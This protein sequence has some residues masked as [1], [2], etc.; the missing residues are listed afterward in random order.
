M[1]GLMSISVM[2]AATRDAP[3]MIDW[4]WPGTT[5]PFLRL[6]FSHWVKD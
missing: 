3:K 5:P 1:G 6:H 4:N 2:P